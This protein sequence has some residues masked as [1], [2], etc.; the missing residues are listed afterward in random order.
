[1]IQKLI[2]KAKEEAEK[3]NEDIL[4]RYEDGE[5]SE[6]E[7]VVF[8]GQTV[9]DDG[10]LLKVEGGTLYCNKSVKY[11][12]P[13]TIPETDR[14]SGDLVLTTTV[15]YKV[16]THNFMTANGGKLIGTHK[17]EELMLIIDETEGEISFGECQDN[18]KCEGLIEWFDYYKGVALL[19]MER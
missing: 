16:Q 10:A 19:P 3:R 14:D 1:M 7:E 4:N 17:D 8:V 6:D 18:G 11:N 5:L 12:A 9:D 2:D 13:E 15:R